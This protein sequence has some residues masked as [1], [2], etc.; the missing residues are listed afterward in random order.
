MAYDSGG[1][2][3]PDRSKLNARA[4]TCKARGDVLYREQEMHKFLWQTLAEIFYPERAD[5]TVERTPGYDQ[6]DGLYTSEPQLLRRNL[7]NK[8]SSMTRAEGT[9]WFKCAAFPEPLM[10]ID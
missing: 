4:K 7:G 5:F 9:Q 2:G 3:K 1:D 10:K 6:Y 8:L